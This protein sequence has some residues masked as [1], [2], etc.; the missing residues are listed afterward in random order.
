MYHSS[1]STRHTH[2][3]A[4][5]PNRAEVT[6][7][8][9]RPAASLQQSLAASRLPPQN[10][11]PA[12]PPRAGAVRSAHPTGEL[13]RSRSLTFLIST[14]DS[15]R[16]AVVA[17]VPLKET[18]RAAG[19]E[20]VERRA[21]CDEAPLPPCPVC[22]AKKPPPCRC[23]LPE[24]LRALRLTCCPPPSG[25][26]PPCEPRLPA[27]PL[28]CDRLLAAAAAAASAPPQVHACILV[29]HCSVDLIK[30][31]FKYKIVYESLPD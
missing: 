26:R 3:A 1:L 5:I 15:E 31:I 7:D 10:G 19:G 13:L 18:R 14:T 25:M 21:S 22:A 11:A 6:A 28:T 4:H 24:R 17:Q 29:L 12:L 16:P 9:Q 2:L 8:V 23:P 20:G 27:C 30:V